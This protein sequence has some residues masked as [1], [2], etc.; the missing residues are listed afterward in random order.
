MSRCKCY[1]TQKDAPFFSLRKN[2]PFQLESLTLYVPFPSYLISNRIE[3]F[4]YLI[5]LVFPSC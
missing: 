4:K 2:I 5:F 1:Y 3:D